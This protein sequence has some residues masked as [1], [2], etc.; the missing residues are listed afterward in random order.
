MIWRRG[1]RKE[2]P[3]STSAVCLGQSGSA[4]EVRGPTVGDAEDTSPVLSAL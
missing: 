2:K 1:R 3:C 4:V